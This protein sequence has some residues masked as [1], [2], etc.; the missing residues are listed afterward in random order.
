MGEKKTPKKPLIY[1]Y[2]V[3]ILIIYL[4]NSVIAP[5]YFSPKVKEI[6][7]GNFLQKVDEGQVSKVEITSNK[8]AVVA[9]DETDKT[10]YVTGRVEDPDLVNRLVKS[11]VEFSQVIPKESSPISNFFTNW[12]L[13]I[14]IFFIIGQLFM[15]FMGNRMGGGNA[16]SFG[17]SNA[18][19][20]VEAQ[21]GKSFADVAGQLKLGHATVRKTFILS[22]L[23]IE[24][25]LRLGSRAAMVSCL[26]PTKVPGVEHC[27]EPCL[28]CSR[29]V[30]V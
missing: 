20:Y 13:P 10:I 1:Y 15:R 21:T 22:L 3:A 16:M 6:S 17:K 28:Q 9:K 12:I 5:M 4:F 2:L 8:I 18:K 19:V 30:V 25:P 11:K 7:Y 23:Q 26:P 14:F 29:A 27:P 24:V